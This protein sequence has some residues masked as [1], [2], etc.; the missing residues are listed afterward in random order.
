MHLPHFVQNV[1]SDLSSSKDF[2]FTVESDAELRKQWKYF[3]LTLV[4]GNEYPLGRIMD[5]ISGTTEHK[6]QQTQRVN[7]PYIKNIVEMK[8]RF[9]QPWE[10]TIVHRPSETVRIL[11]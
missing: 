8:S 3:L 6:T 11:A 4:R 2:K 10:I 9:L 1:E 5:G 7:L